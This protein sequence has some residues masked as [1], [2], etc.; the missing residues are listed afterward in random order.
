MK[1]EPQD[2]M[3]LAFDVLSAK[4]S[5]VSRYYGPYMFESSIWGY[6]SELRLSSY[7]RPTESITVRYILLIRLIFSMAN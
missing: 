6:Y 5:S 4:L 3:V 7:V 1:S 2:I